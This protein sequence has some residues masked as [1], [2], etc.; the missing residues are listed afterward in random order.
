MTYRKTSIRTWPLT[1]AAC[2]VSFILLSSAV[3]AYPPY[4]FDVSGVVHS[5]FDPEG[6]VNWPP[7]HGFVAP[8]RST[9]LRPGELVLRYGKETGNYLSRDLNAT[10][11][12]LAV[13]PLGET[14]LTRRYRVLKP[15]RVW[16][17]TAASWF[18][19]HGGA[20]QLL[21]QR[22]LDVLIRE[23]YLEEFRPGIPARRPPPVPPP[24][25]AGAVA[26]P[27]VDT[28]VVMLPP[29]VVAT[30]W[31]VGRALVIDR[32]S[33]T[34]AIQV[35]PPN[36]PSTHILTSQTPVPNGFSVN[37]TQSF[38]AGAFLGYNK[39]FGNIVV[40]I[41]ADGAWKKFDASASQT[42]V[43]T[44]TYG[45]A[46]FGP[47]PPF[48]PAVV[49]AQLTQTFSGQIGQGWDASLRARLGTFVTPSI[50]TYLTGGPALGNV[51][52][53]FGYSATMN[54]CGL[55][56]TPPTCATP[57]DLTHLE[58]SQTTNG[59]ASW[60]DTRV[61]WTIGSGFETEVAPGWKAR[62]EY[63]FTSFGSVTHNVP[64]ARTCT[65]AAGG[66]LCNGGIP[67]F[68]AV[69]NTS[70]SSVPVTQ[71]ADFQTIRFGLSYNIDDF[72]LGFN[73]GVSGSN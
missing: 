40:G 18:G 3:Q 47:S 28:W 13:G 55:L 10:P 41:E 65:D 25:T 66:A 31:I 68:V 71:R 8:P 27:P 54:L 33:E 52:G 4:W 49:P 43:S 69:P 50:L 45:P 22:N 29:I 34:G 72:G 51:S 73:L 20:N 57:A 15:F 11:D 16:E 39:Q 14:A 60:N 35:F 21:S 12:S 59:A 2:A 19:Q 24:L 17:G 7:D 58:L 9:I 1:L 6:N 30:E 44:A 70:P 64:L 23:R 63:R 56:P 42:T 48:F 53:A 46:F 5:T 62:L 26:S 61:G 67:P 37:G 32:L 36:T 38:T